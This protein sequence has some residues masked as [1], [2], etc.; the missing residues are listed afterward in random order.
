MSPIALHISSEGY[1]RPWA[2][3]EPQMRCGHCKED[4]CCFTPSKCLSRAFFPV[5][6]A[7]CFG[8]SKPFPKVHAC[9][10]LPETLLIPT[11]NA[12]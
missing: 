12:S 10:P 8:I 6:I 9:L 3:K 1:P 4:H 5:R 7:Q 2:V 11:R